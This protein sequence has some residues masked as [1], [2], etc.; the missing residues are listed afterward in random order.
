MVVKDDYV[1]IMTKQNGNITDQYQIFIE[2]K[3]SHLIQKDSWKESFLLEIES[4][5]IPVKTL[6]D[7]NNYKI[8][9][10]PFFNRAERLSQFNEAMTNLLVAE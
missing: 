8:I 3:G 10:F 7:D 9:G 1:L 6:V 4:S 2:P 5:G